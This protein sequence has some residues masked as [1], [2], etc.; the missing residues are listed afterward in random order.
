MDGRE[1]KRGG[2]VIRK[3]R[4]GGDRKEKK[5]EG[6][7]RECDRETKVSGDVLREVE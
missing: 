2:R 6:M 7:I 5:I 4:E 3:R 1:R